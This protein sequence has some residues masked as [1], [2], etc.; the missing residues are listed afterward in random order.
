MEG[1]CLKYGG[2]WARREMWQ[3]VK[4]IWEGK[5]WPEEWSTGLIVP[6]KKKGEGKSVEDHR[7]VTLMTVGYKVYA[8]I[9]KNRLEERVNELGCI[10]DNQTGFRKGMGTIDHIYI[11]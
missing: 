4:D 7:G 2:D 3:V 5:G 10:P 9:L 1:E 11:R 6:I 8:E